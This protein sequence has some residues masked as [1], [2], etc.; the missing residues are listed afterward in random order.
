MLRPLVLTSATA[1]LLAA[2]STPDPEPVNMQP[3]FDKA[4]NAYCM[5]GYSL[6]S[7]ETGGTVC[8][9]DS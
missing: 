2:C 7:S 3:T 4:G 8:A 9:P 1:L 5:E 6:M